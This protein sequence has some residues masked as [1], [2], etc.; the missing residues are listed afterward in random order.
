MRNSINLSINASRL[1]LFITLYFRLRFPN[2]AF[3]KVTTPCR[4]SKS[5]SESSPPSSMKP[6]ATNS[7]SVSSM[8]ILS[9]PVAAGAEGISFCPSKFALCR[10]SSVHPN[11]CASLVTVCNVGR[12]VFPAKS[13]SKVGSGIPD[14]SAISAVVILLC[15]FNLFNVSTYILFSPPCLYNIICNTELQEKNFR[16]WWK[17]LLTSTVRGGIMITQS[18]VRGG[19]E[20]I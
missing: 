16:A 9:V 8:L 1:A 12:F 10:S 13:F 15:F 6:R 20:V 4:K 18:T 5:S 11:K 7:L 2:H 3:I 14:F 17:N 19:T